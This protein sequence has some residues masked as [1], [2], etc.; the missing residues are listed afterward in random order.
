MIH[1]ERKKKDLRTFGLL[2]GGIFTVIGLW[3]LVLRD[4]EPR[5]WALSVGLGLSALAVTLPQSLKKVHWIW[6]TVGHALGW[7]N[8]R[9]LLG[10]IFYGLVTPM[11]VVMRLFGWNPMRL[12]MEP[13][14]NTYRVVQM[15]RPSSHMTRQF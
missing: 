1:E 13:Q 3:P 12:E 6:M 15:P 5:I 4:E 10:V 2:V 11:G 8:T 9:I 14:R 7:V